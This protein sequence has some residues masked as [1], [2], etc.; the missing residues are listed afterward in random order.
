MSFCQVISR[1][2]TDSGGRPRSQPLVVSDLW[3]SLA[4]GK[5]PAG[6]SL[7][8]RARPF[9]IKSFQSKSLMVLL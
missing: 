6:P 3:A 1:A 7:T 5:T 2:A 8:T 9:R 4:L